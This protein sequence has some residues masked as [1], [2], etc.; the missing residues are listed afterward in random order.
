MISVLK[1]NGILD[2]KK[3]LIDNLPSDVFHFDSKTK[4]T[5][6]GKFLISEITR[7]YILE[8]PP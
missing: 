7:K 1:N 8:K 6:S 5:L 4:T 2:L 3:Y